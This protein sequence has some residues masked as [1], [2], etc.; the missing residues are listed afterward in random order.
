MQNVFSGAE[1]GFVAADDTYSALAEERA[2]QRFTP[3]PM[4]SL[5][6]RLRSAQPVTHLEAAVDLSGH[7]LQH[8]FIARDLFCAAE[9][10][11]A[12]AKAA[13]ERHS[14]DERAFDVAAL[15]GEVIGMTRPRAQAL[16]LT[17][18]LDPKGLDT[19]QVIGD[20]NRLRRILV[21]LIDGAVRARHADDIT[22]SLRG[23]ERDHE[24]ALDIAA[25]AGPVTPHHKGG[26]NPDNRTWVNRRI[27]PQLS[28]AV[29]EDLQALLQDRRDEAVKADPDLAVAMRIRLP[30]ARVEPT[31]SQP[32]SAGPVSPDA[33][34][35]LR[36][37]VAEDSDLNRELIQMLLAPFGCVVDEAVNGQAAVEAI[38]AGRYDAVLMDMNMPVMDGFEATRRIRARTDERAQTPILAVTGRALSAD[39]AKIRALGASGHLSKPFSTQEL[40]GAILNCT[41]NPAISA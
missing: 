3:A 41:R 12:E 34:G 7:G 14:W 35:G 39:I 29:T 4:R 27:D 21:K 16:G 33:L 2:M 10:A 8:G 30:V 17:L 23:V 11:V 19:P 37:L 6:L 26:S 1:H 40:V 13:G 38:E 32:K 20:P 5:G 36:I 22:I 28:F 24:F 31:F 15:V 25:A 9:D 18:K